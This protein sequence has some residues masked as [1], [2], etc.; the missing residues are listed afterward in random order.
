MHQ[1]LVHM[2][3]KQKN[4]ITSKNSVISIPNFDNIEKTSKK[5]LTI[6][7]LSKMILEKPEF[8]N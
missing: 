6:F 2:K 3:E 5:E 8:L 7:S 1:K 4:C